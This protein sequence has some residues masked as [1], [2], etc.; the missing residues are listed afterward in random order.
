[1][2]ILFLLNC[3]KIVLLYNPVRD[4]DFFFFAP[5]SYHVDQFA[6]CI[7]LSLLM[8]TSTVLIQEVYRKPVTS[9]LSY[10]TMDSAN[11]VDY[12]TSQVR[13]VMS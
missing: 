13:E 9:E 10:M 7:H 4:C 1:M 3:K 8:M 12:S 11:T 5:Q 2:V 6:I